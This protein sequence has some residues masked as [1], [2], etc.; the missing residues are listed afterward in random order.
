MNK[1]IFTAESATLTKKSE[2]EVFKVI[3]PEN[4]LKFYTDKDTTK[5]SKSFQLTSVSG[6]LPKLKDKKIYNLSLTRI[7]QK[8]KRQMAKPIE[9]VIKL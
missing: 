1:K 4:F 2:N 6:Q 3:T 8:R 9:M 5:D 7:G